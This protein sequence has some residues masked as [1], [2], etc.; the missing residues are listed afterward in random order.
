MLL[1]FEKSN[2][3]EQISGIKKVLTLKSK[4]LI[5]KGGDILSH[6]AAVP[7]A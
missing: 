2:H 6:I 3:Y 7:S 1:Y 5:K 4:D